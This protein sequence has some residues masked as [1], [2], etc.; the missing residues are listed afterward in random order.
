MFCRRR[1]PFVVMTLGAFVAV[2]ANAAPADVPDAGA[3]LHLRSSEDSSNTVTTPSIDRLGAPEIQSGSKTIQMLLELQ[4][5]KPRLDTQPKVASGD[6]RPAH[7]PK[8]R[9]LLPAVTSGQGAFGG[10]F[11]NVKPQASPA[12][13]AAH[14]EWTN[15]LSS[16]ISGSADAGNAYSRDLY[17]TAGRQQRA[18]ADDDLNLK[19]WLPVSVLRFVRENRKAV[20][21]GS[22][23]ALVLVWAGA[24]AASQRRR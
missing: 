6:D 4:P 7:L 17:S 8:L 10:E 2:N 23:V 14:V 18:G 13:P 9:A 5:A 15:D 19:S 11:R 16:R 12:Q 22:L 21:A 20:L 1:L 3:S 24:S